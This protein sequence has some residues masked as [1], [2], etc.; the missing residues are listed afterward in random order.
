MSG[1]HTCSYRIHIASLP[2]RNGSLPILVP[3]DF[4]RRGREGG[5]ITGLG[6]PHRRTHARLHSPVTWSTARTRSPSPRR[7]VPMQQAQ[8]ERRTGDG[9]RQW[10]QSTPGAQLGEHA[11][12]QTRAPFTVE[13]RL[14]LNHAA[15]RPPP[16]PPAVV[17]AG[18]ETRC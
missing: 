10:R 14:P 4:R 16:P 17:V 2:P 13:S 12:P 6:P 8:V 7:H 5:A 9:R 18:V 11:G 1:R 15:A 3:H